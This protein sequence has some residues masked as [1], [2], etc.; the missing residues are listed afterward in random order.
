MNGR[1]E[2]RLL[3]GPFVVGIDIST[4]AID[5]VALDENEDKATWRHITIDGP[6]AFTRCRRIAD[7][8]TFGPM[9]DNAYLVALERPFIRKGQDV[10]RL[11]QG[12]LLGRIPSRLPVWE[13]PVS[14]WKNHAKIPMR[15]KPDDTTFP[16]VEWALPVE[17]QDTYDALG[18]ALYA[19][20][21]NA[22]GIAAA[23]NP[24]KGQAA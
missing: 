3:A 11:A 15:A 17:H 16:D 19:R 4:R 5:L 20:D 23:L 13:V 2:T 18:V 12:V 1:D 14:Q 22:A 9:F 6:D 21:T 7:I 8:A 10:I 24:P